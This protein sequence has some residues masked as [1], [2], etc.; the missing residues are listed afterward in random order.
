ML[1]V[2]TKFLSFLTSANSPLRRCCEIIVSVIN[3]VSELGS[4]T[5][6]SAKQ[7]VNGTRSSHRA[8]VEENNTG[9]VTENGGKGKIKSYSN[10][11]DTTGLRRSSRETSSKK[12]ISSPSS[13]HKSGQ[14]E[15]RAPPT[16]AVKRKSERVGKKKMP[17]PLR[18]SGRTRSHSSA[19]PSDSKSSG[20]LSSN[21][22]PK[23]EKSVRQLTFEAKEV[24]ENEEHDP[25]TPQVQV[26]RMTARMYRSLFKLPNSKEDC[27]PEPNRINKSNQ[28]GSNGGGKIDD[29]SK[30]SH[31]DCK[32]V[33]K[34]GALPSEDGKSK[35]MRVDSGLSGPV[36]DLT[37]N[38][39]TL[40]SLAPSNAA[41]SEIG[42]APESNQPDYCREE[43]IQ[44]LVSSN[45][46]L[47]EDLIRNSVGDD[48][49]EK[50]SPSKRKGITVNVDVDSDV[51]ATLTKGDNC[52]LITDG[53]PS[54]LSRLGGNTM[55][56]DRSS[57]AAIYETGLA[58]ERVQ[59]D[60]CREETL[61]MLPSSNSILNEDLNRNSVGHVSSVEKLVPSKRKGIT[62]DMDSDVSAT[63]A[64]GDNCNLIPDGSSPSQLGGNI[65]GTDGSCSK[66]IRIATRIKE[67]AESRKTM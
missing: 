23:K 47:D 20:S 5:R 36:K 30:G 50:L 46:I 58:P 49:G 37:E 38:T 25:G 64:K 56:I 15:K 4:H 59:P 61:Q 60:C 6:C 3:A 14:L 66:R 32:E 18:R 39:V 10:V 19:S 53:S 63:L 44:M 65:M 52:N 48:R 40:G 41:T 26:K 55:G 24:N 42:L 57:N 28:G 33:S 13:T 31:S 62:V 43:T 22:K 9:R 12:I 11:S 27:L 29:C 1:N 51:C 8:K 67:I 2:V 7:M 21:P 16:P 54:S 34:N 35:D 45:S 17:S